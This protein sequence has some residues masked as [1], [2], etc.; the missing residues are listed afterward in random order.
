MASVD[1]NKLSWGTLPKTIREKVV[2]QEWN[3]LANLKA[4][5][6]GSRPFPIKL[7]L[8]P[9]TGKQAAQAFDQFRFF[10]DQWKQF[11]PEHCVLWEQKSFRLVSDQ[12][13]PKMF[14][15]HNMQEFIEFVGQ[16]AQRR[17]KIWQ[18]NML[19]VL[20]F[21]QDRQAVYPVLVKHLEKIETMTRDDARL[22]AILLPQLAENMGKGGYL[23]GLPLV[24]VDTKF[25]EHYQ[26]L[27]TDLLNVIHDGAIER[28]GGLMQWLNCIHSPKGWLFVRPLCRLLRK[29]MG[30]FELLQLTSEHLREHPIPG[31]CVLVVENAQSGFALPELSQT[32]AVFGGGRN[33]G[34]MD[35]PWLKQRHVGYW[36]D[37]DTWGL[38]ILSDARNHCPNLRPVMMDEATIN[39]FSS[40]MVHENE[41]V[42]DTPGT[43]TEVEVKL[44]NDL[45]TARFNASRLEQE[46]LSPDYIQENL[47]Q[48]LAQSCHL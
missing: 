33:V 21:V 10:V 4:R 34:W 37:I 18:Q 15:I 40:R 42:P 38:L 14:V 22:L 41:H 39:M 3:N 16:E 1:A 46:R 9:P 27:V 2:K 45:K 17:A 29:E 5:L 35:A 7:G 12:R 6:I 20:N 36:G 24:E 43:L 19:P 11:E 32:V 30:G 25:L 26:T 48:W 23:R 28:R 44:F 31:E 13:V 8:R 47:Q